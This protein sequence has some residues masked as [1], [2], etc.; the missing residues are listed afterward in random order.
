MNSILGF[1]D[2]I[3]KGYY[4]FVL[5]QLLDTWVVQS[6]ANMSS[7]PEDTEKPMPSPEKEVVFKFWI[8]LFAGFLEPQNAYW[9]KTTINCCSCN[10]NML[11]FSFRFC[12]M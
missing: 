2:E 10:L 11:V 8:S 4:S 5:L 3:F 12:L 6:E 7:E 1:S 9:K